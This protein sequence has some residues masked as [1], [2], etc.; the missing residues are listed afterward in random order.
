MDS[1]L[2]IEPDE[3]VTRKISDSTQWKPTVWV[4]DA[5]DSNQVAHTLIRGVKTAVKALPNASV[6]REKIAFGYGS[7]HLQI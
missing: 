6:S 2:V 7:M 3:Q 1:L 5:A 4:S